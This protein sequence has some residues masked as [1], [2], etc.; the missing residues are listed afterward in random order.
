MARKAPG[1]YYRKGISLKKIFQL[2]PDDQTAEAFFANVRWP[3]GPRCPYCN[4]DNIQTGTAHKTMPY[5]CRRD[6]CRKRFSVRIGSAMEASNL[7]YQTWAVAIFLLTQQLEGRLQH[8]TAQ[9]S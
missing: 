8:E 7:G 1:K 2:F 6:G 5:R 9:R 3:D 4:H